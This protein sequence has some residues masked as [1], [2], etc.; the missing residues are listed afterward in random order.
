[1]LKGA[2]YGK[3][4]ICKGTKLQ[5]IRLVLMMAARL[6]FKFLRSQLKRFKSLYSDNTAIIVTY[7]FIL[8]KLSTAESF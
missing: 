1:V 6:Q 7:R 4:V 8:M 2:K 3:A 5:S